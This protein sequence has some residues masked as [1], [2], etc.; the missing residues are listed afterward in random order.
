MK[1]LLKMIILLVVAFVLFFGVCYL[2][3]CQLDVG[4]GASARILQETE[5]AA[6][7][8]PWFSYGKGGE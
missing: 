1:N 4:A 7:R 2:G 3:G 8:N 6:S 5:G